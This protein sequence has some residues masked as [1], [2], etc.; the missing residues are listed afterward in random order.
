MS[1][2]NLNILRHFLCRGRC[3]PRRPQHTAQYSQLFSADTLVHG[4]SMPASVPQNFGYGYGVPLRSVF[5]YKISAYGYKHVC[6][7]HFPTPPL[8]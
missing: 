6:R 8:C 1:I 7:F 2:L 5:Q 3:R 4:N